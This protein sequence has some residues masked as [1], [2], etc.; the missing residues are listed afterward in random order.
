MQ[1]GESDAGR[2][3]KER[4]TEGRPGVVFGEHDVSSQKRFA[5][6]ILFEGTYAGLFLPYVNKGG[7]AK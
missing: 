3:S 2:F 4:W 7:T 5:A 1:R 6:V